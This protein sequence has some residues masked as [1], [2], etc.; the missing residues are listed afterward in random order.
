MRFNHNKEQLKSSD[1]SLSVWVS[2]SAGTGKTKI[3]TDRVLKLLLQGSAPSKILCLTFTKAAAC[4]MLERVNHELKLWHEAS[5]EV[6]QNSLFLLF[7]QSPTHQEM[8]TAKNLFNILLNSSEQLQIQTIHGFCQSLLKLF[9]FEASITPG[10]EVIDDIKSR[11]LISK[12]SNSVFD[13]IADIEEKEAFNFIE[14]NIHD[15]Y[16]QNLQNEIIDARIKFKFLLDHFGNAKNYETFL[17]ESMDITDSL[18]QYFEEFSKEIKELKIYSDVSN[19]YSFLEEY[20]NYLSLPKEERSKNFHQ[21]KEVFLTK[22]D[23]PRRKIISSKRAKENPDLLEFIEKVQNHI[24]K[25]DQRRKAFLLIRDSKFLFLLASKLVTNYDEAKKKLGYLDYDDLI[26]FANKLLNNSDSK[27]WVLYKLDGGIDHILIDEA[28]DTSPEQWKIISALMHEFYSGNDSTGR[29]IFVV[30]DEKQ[31]IYSFQ[32]ADLKAFQGMKEFLYEQMN[33]SYRRYEIVDLAFSYR[34]AA[35]IV[36]FVEVTFDRLSKFEDYN[37]PSYNN[38]QCFRSKHQGC[39]EIWPVI[40]SEEGPELFWPVCSPSTSQ[41]LG[42]KLGVNIANYVKNLIE[43]KVVLPS[44]NRVV[45]EKDILILI[46]KRDANSLDMIKALQKSGLGMSGID[47][48]TIS[49]SL[50]A[51]DIISLA[52]FVLQPFD[53]LNL[54]A[55]LKSPFFSLNDNELK[56]IIIY[57]KTK[58]IWENLQSLKKSSLPGTEDEE[59]MPGIKEIARRDSLALNDGKFYNHHEFRSKNHEIQKKLSH[60]YSLIGSKLEEFYEL[61]L[62]HSVQDFFHVILNTLGYRKNL[63]KFGGEESSDI[64][65]EFLTLSTNF[66]RDISSNLQEFVIWFEKNNTEIKR[67]VEKNNKIRIMTIHGAKGLQAPIVIIADNGSLPRNINNIIWT[68]EDIALWTSSS[69]NHDYLDKHKKY[70]K[71]LE[72]EE[73]LRL[74]YVAMTRAEDKLIMAGYRDKTSSD[75]T[76][77]SWHN[78]MQETMQQ[79]ES[80]EEQ[81][82]FMESPVLIYKDPSLEDIVIIESAQECRE[83]E[84]SLPIIPEPDPIMRKFTIMESTSRLMDAKTAMIFGSIFHKIME[85]TIRNMDFSIPKIHPMLN[86]LP[87]A[88]REFIA[89]KIEQILDL[90]EFQKLLK[91]EIKTEV[92]IGIEIDGKT[93][94]GRI[95]FMAISEDRIVILDYKTG[96]YNASNPLPESYIEQLSFYKNTISKIYSNHIVEAKILWVDGPVLS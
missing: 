58:S 30:G 47:R 32:G 20:N 33:L 89:S 51:K 14:R 41:S 63:L 77:S 18:E 6:L 74:L 35:A 16:L 91:L 93:R 43:S 26:Y 28:Q 46:R 69:Y 5:E 15:I 1:P 81:Y 72:Y 42:W 37:F 21:I 27:E 76:Y 19:E 95:D 79:L 57:D 4:E 70:N 39:V 73:Y 17:K 61:Y 86:I 31:S 22:L 88:Q 8:V 38:L 50:E 29:T 84:V 54:A 92:N 56:E 49:K 45:S 25:L 60:E 23:M 53:D 44:T 71:K 3:L 34:S 80:T 12:V 7:G 24:I 65:N 2:A 66:A 11:D 87:V 52:K 85:D 40:T 82:S 78:I 13:D 64:I 59:E 83:E 48:L 90:E 94:V 10:F 68:K 67:I 62:A 96:S 55:L 36:K 75:S 9:P